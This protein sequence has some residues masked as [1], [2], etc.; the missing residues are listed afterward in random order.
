MN[1]T[2][3]TLL[4][5]MYENNPSLTRAKYDFDDPVDLLLVQ[6]D[7][8][9]FIFG[10]GTDIEGELSLQISI[11]LL[12]DA[13]PGNLIKIYTQDEGADD[14]I[15]GGIKSFLSLTPIDKIKTMFMLLKHFIVCLW[16]KITTRT[17][18]PFKETH[19]YLEW[20]VIDIRKK[21]NI[22]PYI[23]SISELAKLLNAA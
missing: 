18:F 20:T 21:Y 8:Q 15:E 4:D 14:F 19:K 1:T 7:A 9:H 2:L 12:S 10:C 5:R 6:H 22:K 13:K 3:K 17:R 11:F 16:V 23:Y